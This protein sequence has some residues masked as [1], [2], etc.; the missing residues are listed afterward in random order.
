MLDFTPRAHPFAVLLLCASQ[1]DAQLPTGTDWVV[2]SGS[3]LVYDTSHGPLELHSLTI[4]AGATLR[5]EG[6]Q[7]FVLR[8]L[9]FV[10]LEG[11]LDCSG[12][13][14]APVA[15]GSS[16][17][18][19]ELGAPGG[20]GGGAGGTASWTLDGSTAHGSAGAS[21]SGVQ[22]GQKAGGRG[23]ESTFALFA[24]GEN[25]AGGGGGGRLAAD[26]LYPG[27]GPAQ[28]G[29][30]AQAGKDGDPLS[31]GAMSQ[32][33]P[34]QGGLPGTS[35]VF[36]DATNANDFWGVLDGGPSFGLI[37]GEA[38][39]PVGGSGGGAG[40]D[41]STT[42]VFPMPVWQPVKESKGAG[43]GGGG[44]VCLLSTP[45]L[46]VG[47]GGRILA[48]GGAGASGEGPGP[49]GATG[50][51]SGGG[52]G[53]WIVLQTD[54]LDLSHSQPA[55]LNAMGGAG[56]TA[57]DPQLGLSGSGG[58][59]GPGVIQVHLDPTTGVLLLPPGASLHS[60]GLPDP[61]Q[62]LPLLP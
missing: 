62:L 17:R 9:E 57:S 18:A 5:V 4:E 24:G 34:A 38:A 41:A 23:G 46:I 40:G 21:G 15:L 14:A 61:L 2:P 48:R 53:G 20:P 3:Q 60:R 8:A 59:G 31:T 35:P 54:L 22:A 50:G 49:K 11:V 51:A 55:C 13:D 6:P 56:G 16:T 52:S 7:A 45:Q 58:N 37:V 27:F 25:R 33:G 36:R 39:W 28:V 32:Q 19:P 26:L 29:D 1:L 44:G 30:L 42:E 12:F 43:G 47:G 10:H